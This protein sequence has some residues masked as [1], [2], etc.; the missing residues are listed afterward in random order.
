MA[1]RP[2]PSWTQ[3]QKDKFNTIQQATE[4]A[5]PFFGAEI[6]RL[7]NHTP[8]QLCDMLGVIKAAGK[9]F[10]TVENQLKERF[11]PLMP[12]RAAGMESSELRGERYVANLR[13]APRVAL[14]QKGIKEDLLE[15]ADTLCVNLERL[16]DA[17]EDGKIKVP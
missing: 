2:N 11:K 14:N 6:V 12:A 3:P 8:E 13:T 4:T 17:V 9:S 16:L 15:R 7:D 5:I 1:S 10:E